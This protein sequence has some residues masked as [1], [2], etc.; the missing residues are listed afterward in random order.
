MGQ[1]SE[2]IYLVETVA[3]IENLQVKTPDMLAY[4]TQTTL[5]VDDTADMIATL[6]RKFPTIAEPK[7][8]DICYATTNRQEAVKFMA[9]QVDV[10][11][12][13]GSPNSSNANRLREV[14]ETKGALAY[15]VENASQINPAWL[16]GK[17]RIGVTAGASSPEILVQGGSQSLEGIW[18]EKCADIGRRRGG[19]HFPAAEGVVAK[20]LVNNHLKI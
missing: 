20:K 12:V 7:K 3:D 4:V 1:A 19:S 17:M 18:C 8:G 2:G 10:V 9:L 6:K 15:M 5:S 14:A 13:I 11:I 16:E